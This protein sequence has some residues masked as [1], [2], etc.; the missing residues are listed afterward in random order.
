MEYVARTNQL[1]MGAIEQTIAILL[2]QRLNPPTSQEWAH[3]REM[4]C[5]LTIKGDEA[6]TA[7]RG[8]PK[9]TPIGSEIRS[10]LPSAEVL[11]SRGATREALFHAVERYKLA[12]RLNQEVPPSVL[13]VR[14][15][16]LIHLKQFSCNGDALSYLLVGCPSICLGRLAELPCSR[17]VLRRKLSEPSSRDDS[18]AIMLPELFSGDELLQSRDVSGR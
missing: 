10:A 2:A 11:G 3:L 18:L 8:T 5:W 1:I 17:R 12:R 9:F 15:R 13:K 7:M 4:I 6:V 14:S 16:S